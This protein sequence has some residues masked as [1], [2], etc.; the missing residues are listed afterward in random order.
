[1]HLV[2][3]CLDLLHGIYKRLQ[4]RIEESRWKDEM[5]RGIDEVIFVTQ[6]L[7]VNFSTIIL[8]ETLK[9]LLVEDETVLDVI[10][11]LNLIV[12]S[13]SL[14]L[15]ELIKEL[16]THL[17]YMIMGMPVSFCFFSCEENRFNFDEIICTFCF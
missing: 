4:V 14:P 7:N 1:M 11:K 9:K 10:T 12:T 8:P 17:R 6:E 2:T 15:N 16:Q 3:K 5:K 13:C